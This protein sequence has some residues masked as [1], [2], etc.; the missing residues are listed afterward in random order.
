MAYDRGGDS[1]FFKGF[2][3]GG[4]IGA[5]KGRTDFLADPVPKITFSHKNSG[6]LR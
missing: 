1:G 4:I 2:L 5:D 6:V 3:F